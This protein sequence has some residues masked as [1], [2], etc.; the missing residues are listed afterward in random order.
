MELNS[1]ARSAWAQLSIGLKSARAKLR[2]DERSSSRVGITRH[3]AEGLSFKSGR[4]RLVCVRREGETRVGT[5]EATKNP[6]RASQGEQ[7]GGKC[8]YYVGEKPLSRVL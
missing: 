5:G 7:F 2:P 4:V 8:L 1:T 3:P 6:V